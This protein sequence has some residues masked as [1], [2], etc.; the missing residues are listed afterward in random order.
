MTLGIQPDFIICRSDYAID[1]VRKDKVAM[2]CNVAKDDIISNPNLESIYELPLYFEKQD[3]GNKILGKFGIESR[4]SNLEK[5]KQFVDNL[6]DG[7]K[8]VKIGIV[9]KYFDVGEYKLPDAYVSVIE[10]IKHAAANNLVKA[11]IA[12]IDSK[13]FEK[14]KSKLNLLKNFDGIIVPGGFGPSGVEGKILAIRF[15]RENNIPFLGLCYGLQLAV[16]EY[17][18]NVC[19]LEDAHTTEIEQSCANPVIDFLPW[20][21]KLMEESKYGAT[22]RLGGQMVLIKP[23]TLAHKLYGKSETIERFRHRYEINPKYVEALEKSNFVFSGESKKDEGIMQIGE[24][25]DHKF[26]VGSQFHPEFTSRPLKPNPLYDGFI[27]AC[28]L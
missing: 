16:I 14:D 11:E 9:G 22:M 24:L 28:A 10:A 13:D 17:A 15:V 3:F 4:N 12:W 1:E 25:A 23:N 5:W 27:K 8:T 19:K 26:F 2:F 20:Q 7:K 6:N 18:R 21:K